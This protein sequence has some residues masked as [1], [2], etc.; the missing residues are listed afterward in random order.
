MKRYLTRKYKLHLNNEQKQMLE[1]HFGHNRFIWN[2]L[3]ELNNQA[4]NDYRNGLTDEKTNVNYQYFDKIVTQLKKE[5]KFLKEASSITYQFTTKQL[6]KAF[7]SFFKNTKH[8]KPPKFKKK[9]NKQSVGYLNTQSFNIDFDNRKIKVPVIGWIKF[10]KHQKSVDLENYKLK[11]VN[12]TK[13]TTG[14]YYMS[15]TFEFVGSRD[16]VIIKESN[17]KQYLGI[18]LGVKDFA[19]LSNGIKIDN[20]K[21]LTK[22]LKKLRRVSRK[23]SHA[24]KGSKNRKKRRLELAKIHE[25]IKN[26]RM[27]FIKQTVAKIVKI[28]KDNQ[29]DG[30]AVENLNVAG[31]MKNRRLARA[32]GELGWNR[33]IE[34]LEYKLKQARFEFKKIDRFFASSQ[35]CSVCGYKN[36]EVKNLS[37]RKWACPQCGTIHDRDINAAINIALYA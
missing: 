29:L 11:Q 1:I 12:I 4:Y 17:N 34:F 7:K 2:K 16:I 30:I 20:P 13:T 19:V 24:K 26:Q 14:K 36:P 15:L 9:Q 3:L 22:S 25:K 18:D 23:H 10:E 33:F 5:Y 28:V 27:D 37:V 6:S 32:I 8:F 35:T 31:M 21:F